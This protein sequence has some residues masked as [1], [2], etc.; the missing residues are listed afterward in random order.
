ML[1]EYPLLE[2]ATLYWPEHS[3]YVSNDIEDMFDFLAPFFQKKS[4]IRENW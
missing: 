1:Q 2:Y 3:R 4:Q